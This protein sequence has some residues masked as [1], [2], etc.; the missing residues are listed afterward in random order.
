MKYIRSIKESFNHN[1]NKKNDLILS[2]WG[3]TEDEIFDSLSDIEDDFN[4]TIKC[5]FFLESPSKKKF[6][7]TNNDEQ[8]E[9]FAE[10]GFRPIIGIYIEST[11]DIELIQSTLLD[12]IKNLNDWCID[13]MDKLKHNI[14]LYISPEKS[15]FK[16]MNLYHKKINSY[17][18]N[19][20]TEFKKNHFDTYIKKYFIKDKTAYTVL[21]H[22][23]YDNSVKKLYKIEFMKL[24]T[25]N[26]TFIDELQ[27]MKKNL[28]NIIQELNKNEDFY[29]IKSGF[30]IKPTINRDKENQERF[31]N[32]F[33]IRIYEK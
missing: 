23:K 20:F 32:I 14:S 15:D 10:S 4:V 2:I 22:F 11:D 28:E 19:L 24:Y 21:T 25:P 30:T 27:E 16:E 8:M 26:L 17:F 29:D 3:I 13:D 5:E 7:L 18:T 6:Q 33:S 9:A 12:S 1:W 31:V